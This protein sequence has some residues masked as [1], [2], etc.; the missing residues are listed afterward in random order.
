IQSYEARLAALPEGADPGPFHAKIEERRERKGELEKASGELP[1]EGNQLGYRFAAITQDLE[2]HAE[3]R[4]ILAD[5]DREVSE[6]NLAFARENP[7][8]CPEPAA[9]EA[10]FVGQATCAACHPAAQAFWETT[11]HAKAYATLE[12]AHKQYDL[13]CISCHVTGGDRPG[14]ACQIGKVEG[15]KDVGCESCP[16]P[17]SL[18]AAAPSKENIELGVPEQTC[19]SCHRPDHSLEF[20]YATYL[21]RIL[22]PGHGEKV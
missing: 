22:G 9:G 5:Y 17:G 21:S 7:R 20:D 6:A 8:P 19:R 4:K 13:S 14:G 2:P 10:T 12:E 3:V 11:S 15:R 18:H 16:G 1:A